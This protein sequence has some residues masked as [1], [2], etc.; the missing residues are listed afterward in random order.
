MRS[1]F[2][3]S[4]WINLLKFNGQLPITKPN[5]KNQ[6]PYTNQESKMLGFFSQS[7]EAA[8][9]TDF[10]SQ[11]HKGNFFKDIDKWT[12][13]LKKPKHKVLYNFAGRHNNNAR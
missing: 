12:G 5:S 2:V 3:F 10:R 4:S 8:G 1:V 6:K 9:I 11:I 7:V 13:W